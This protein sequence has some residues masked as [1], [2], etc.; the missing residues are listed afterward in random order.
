MNGLYDIKLKDKEIALS[1]EELVTMFNRNISKNAELLDHIG[2]NNL[3]GIIGKARNESVHSH[4]VAELLSGDFFNGDSREST[5]FHFL[6]LLLYRSAKERKS[7]EINPNFKKEI[8]TRSVLFEKAKSFCELPVQKYQ[9]LQGL[10][11]TRL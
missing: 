5:L 2:R 6:D 3:F 1:A 11:K 7:G 4:F 8:L 9:K 10:N